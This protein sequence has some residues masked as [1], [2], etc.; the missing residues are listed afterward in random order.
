MFSYKRGKRH[1]R[2][3]IAGREGDVH[4]CEFDVMYFSFSLTPFDYQA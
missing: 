3:K 2:D 1:S 4:M